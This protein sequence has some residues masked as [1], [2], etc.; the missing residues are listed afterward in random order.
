ML[1]EP[2]SLYSSSSRRRSPNLTIPKH[3][4]FLLVPSP[5][6]TTTLSTVYLRCQSTGSITIAQANQSLYSSPNSHVPRG[7]RVAIEQGSWS[8]AKTNLCL[9]S[10]QRRRAFTVKFAKCYTLATGHF[11]DLPP[12]TI[13]VC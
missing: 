8:A 10:R 3:S 5:S 1:F 2:S 4:I 11:L 9:G 7:N 13:D 6:P 12:Q